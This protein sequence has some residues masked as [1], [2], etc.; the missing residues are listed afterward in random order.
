M[1]P[2]A[3]R[4]APEPEVQIKG[5]SMAVQTVLRLWRRRVQQQRDHLSR[6][7]L[8]KMRGIQGITM[9]TIVHVPWKVAVYSLNSH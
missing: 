9:G 8:I 4:A 5:F 2:E 7:A 6:L 3:T 1:A